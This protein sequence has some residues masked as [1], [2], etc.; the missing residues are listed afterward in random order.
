MSSRE[1]KIGTNS[2]EIHTTDEAHAFG[3]S[4]H[5]E[6][7]LNVPNKLRNRLERTR[8]CLEQVEEVGLAWEAPDEPSNKT[9]ARD[10]V[11]SVTG[12]GHKIQEQARRRNRFT[13]SR[14][15]ARGRPGGEKRRR[16]GAI[17]ITEML[18]NASD[19]MGYY[20]R[21]TAQRV[22]HTA[23][24]LVDHEEQGK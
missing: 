21:R 10:D 18:V 9:A 23:Q 5:V 4:G 11:Q 14:Q 15:R 7:V 8:E 1:W 24:C 6:D 16:G 2:N 3:A 20:G 17:G 13:V 22:A 12:E 19:T